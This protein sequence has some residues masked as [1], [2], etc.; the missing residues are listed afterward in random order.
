MYV[1]DCIYRCNDTVLFLESKGIQ[2]ADYI[3]SGGPPQP[4]HSIHS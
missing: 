1:Y 4:V 3:I 2:R